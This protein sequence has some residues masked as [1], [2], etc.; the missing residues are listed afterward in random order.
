MIEAMA[1]AL[2]CVG[3]SAGGIPELLPPEAIVPAGDGAALTDKICEVLSDPSRMSRM[4]A[5]NLEKARAYRN[6]VLQ[7]RR[8]AFYRWV[9][10]ATE[11]W[12]RTRA[13]VASGQ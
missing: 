13:Q 12:H 6:A 8:I 9:Q 11:A 7:P 3:S 10:E 2:P 4:S 5:R 1:R